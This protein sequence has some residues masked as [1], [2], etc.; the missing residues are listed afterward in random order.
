ML[1]S[2]SENAREALGGLQ[3]NRS[4]PVPLLAGTSAGVESK[5]IA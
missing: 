3:S 5:E 1:I 2:L 4:V